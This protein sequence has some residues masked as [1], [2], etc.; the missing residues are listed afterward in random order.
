[1]P[2]M[3]ATRAVRAS[4]SATCPDTPALRRMIDEASATPVATVTPTDARSRT[5]S[6][7][8]TKIP[9]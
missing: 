7:S 8:S 1:M 5:G 2:V 9:M 4:A 3:A 6:G